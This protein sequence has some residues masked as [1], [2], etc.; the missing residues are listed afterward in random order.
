MNFEMITFS[1]YGYFIWPAFI[2]AFLCC[3]LLYASTKKK[4][5]KYDKIYSNCFKKQK[6]LKI[7]IE[8]NNKKTLSKISVF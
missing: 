4:L 7:V 8:K 5:L 2:F 6:V 1:G 3:F